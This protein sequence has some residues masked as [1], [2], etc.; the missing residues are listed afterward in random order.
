MR[1]IKMYLKYKRKKVWPSGSIY[2]RVD[3]GDI[4]E[5]NLTMEVEEGWNEVELWDFDFLSR[6]DFLWT[7]RIKVDDEVGECTNT[8]TLVEKNSSASYLLE[9]EILA[10]KPV[11]G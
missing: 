10:E 5:V 6:N 2:C 8:M 11:Y 3:T 7:F 1:S 9:L 4:A